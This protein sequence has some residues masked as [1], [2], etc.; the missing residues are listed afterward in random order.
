MNIEEI[1]ITAQPSLREH[2]GLNIY[3]IW[4][5]RMEA[6]HFGEDSI[7]FLVPNKHFAE[8]VE[9]N[10]W[11]K[12]TEILLAL[13]GQHIQFVSIDKSSAIE[14]IKPLNKMQ[15]TRVIEGI[16]PKKT[17]DNFVV[18]V[19]NQFAHAASLAVA[20]SPGDNQYN[21]LF[22][23][24]STGLGKTHLL[25]AIAN[26]VAQYHPNVHP[27]YLTAELFMND[28]IENIRFKTMSSFKQKYRDNCQLLLMD[29][30]QFLTG[31]PQTQEE[32][33]H[34][35]EYLKQRGHQ[36]V[37]TADVLPREI[38]GLEPRLRTRCESGM[39]ADTQP[40]DLETML[41][42]IRQ[43]S[44]DLSISIQKQVASYIA[45]SVRGNV[46]EVEGALNKLK[47]T[48]QL[49]QRPI[50]L[51][52]A[53]QHLGTLFQKDDNEDLDINSII[54]TVATAFNIR[55][56]DIKGKRRTKNLI[57]PRHI[58]MYL[59][60]KHTNLSYPE[61]GREFGN[62][63]HGSILYGCNKI[64]DALEQNPNL[65][66]TIDLIERDLKL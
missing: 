22:I 15:V 46:R 38:E 60:R 8:Y 5:E 59:V 36:I 39:L 35:F 19:C 37:F 29:D 33:F 4:I 58:A 48:S 42:I 65:R 45:K 7:H 61:I 55:S 41:A 57:K 25:Y 62:R 34:T 20:D 64:N 50:D 30:I 52:F 12:I 63:D 54:K 23:Y 66:Q 49:L 1:W 21:P 3:D 47:A 17:F 43:K 24:G 2:I 26:K 13:T 28:M 56:S 14:S 32:L 10:I 9:K 18:G 53:I 16:P 40:P 31:K 27:L 11:P 6:T 51:P 44:S